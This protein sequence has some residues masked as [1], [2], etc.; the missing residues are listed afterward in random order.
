MK[1]KLLTIAFTLFTIPNAFAA[2]RITAPVDP[3]IRCVSRGLPADKCTQYRDRALATNCITQEE[4]NDLVRYGATPTCDF[5]NQLAGWCPC[6]CFHPDSPIAT[7]NKETMSEE[8]TRAEDVAKNRLKFDLVHMT[9]SSTLSHV[10]VTSSPIVFSAEG[11]ETKPMIVIQTEDNRKLAVT[12]GHPILLSN[13]QMVQA[14]TINAGDHLVGRFGEALK[15]SN[16]NTQM[17]DGHVFNFV[18]D[19]F[20]DNKEHVIFSSDIAVGDLYWQSLLED[21][22]SREAMRN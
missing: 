21:E 19:S 17:F 9:P 13:G 22:S 15:V 16:V 6:G 5:D 7:I 4:Y 3:A 11:P 8:L 20:N 2:S 14:K 10:E 1:R 18:V 12:E